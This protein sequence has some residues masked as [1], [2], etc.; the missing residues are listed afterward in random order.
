M[1]QCFVVQGTLQSGGVQAEKV[2]PGHKLAAGGLQTLCCQTCLLYQKCLPVT[3]SL[4]YCGCNR[5]N[6]YFSK[7]HIP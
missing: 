5:R 1:V 6:G 2:V 7:N 3:S 4:N